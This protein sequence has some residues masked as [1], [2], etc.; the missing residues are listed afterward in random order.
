MNQEEIKQAIEV[1][2][3]EKNQALKTIK[4]YGESIVHRKFIEVCNTALISLYYREERYP[5]IE[6]GHMFVCKNCNEQ[7][8]SHSNRKLKDIKF[9]DQCGQKVKW[10][11]E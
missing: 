10:R 2:H 3:I 5:F 1:L 11:K 7:I 8:Y 9:C 6:N 4:E